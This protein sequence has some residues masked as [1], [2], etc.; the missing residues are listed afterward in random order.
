MP[1]FLFRIFLCDLLCGSP[2]FVPCV[3]WIPPLHLR[4][5]SRPDSPLTPPLNLVTLAWL[6][7]CSKLLVAASLLS[8][9]HLCL[10][11]RKTTTKKMFAGQLCE[12]L[13]AGMTYDWGVLALIALAQLLLGGIWY[14]VI[15]RHT[16]HY[17]HSVANGVKGGKLAIQRYG[18]LTQSV[19]SIFLSLIRAVV[20]ELIAFQVKA[21]TLCLYQEIGLFVAVICITTFHHGFW[22]QQPW[23]LILLAVSHEIAVCLLSATLSFYTRGVSLI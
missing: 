11:P 17:W 6:L 7:H 1:S 15:F 19:V 4:A 13:F 23:Q 21:S 18:G 12:K 22:S 16:S 3:W 10:F 5:P 14:E 2:F 9:F 20:I 8:R